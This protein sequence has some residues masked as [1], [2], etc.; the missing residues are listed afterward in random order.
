MWN[1]THVGILITCD[2][3]CAHEIKYIISMAQTVFNKQKTLVTSKLSFKTRRK[4][5]KCYTWN[6]DLYAAG[7]LTF[8]KIYQKCLES[9]ALW[10]RRRMEKVSWTGHIRWYYLENLVWQRSWTGNWM[11]LS[12][13]DR[14]CV[15]S[16]EGKIL[17]YVKYGFYFH[18]LVFSHV[19]RGAQDNLS[20]CPSESI[21]DHISWDTKV[22]YT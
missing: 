4:L 12:Q 8:R 2:A 13:A 1:V 3:R 16:N 6:I 5:T 21:P 20:F 10:C 7:N 11:D 17:H 18:V 14:D 15:A 19:R 22:K 9:R